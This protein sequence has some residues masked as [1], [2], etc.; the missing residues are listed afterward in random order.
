MRITAQLD[1]ERRITAIAF[2]GEGCTISKAAA[3]LFTEMALGKR[4]DDVLA[5]T[6]EAMADL[7]G[8]ELVTQRIHCVTLALN[9]LRDA[10]NTHNLDA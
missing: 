6:P 7:L 3:S 10:A 2:D 9:T 5:I 8:E 1:S 4:L